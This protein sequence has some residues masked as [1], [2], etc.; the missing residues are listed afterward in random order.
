MRLARSRAKRRSR[1]ET[2]NGR[3]LFSVQ[4]DGAGF[5]ARVVRGLGLLGME[6]RVRR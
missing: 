4:D 6:E 2:R 5:D 3:V 1:G